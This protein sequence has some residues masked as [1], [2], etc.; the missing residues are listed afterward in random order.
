MDILEFVVLSFCNLT[1]LF[2]IVKRQGMASVEGY[3]AV[4]LGMAV[5]TDNLGLLFDYFFQP[6]TLLLGT[7]EFHFRAYPTTV[8]I[9]AMIVLM[10]GL[11]LGNPK[12]E[13]IS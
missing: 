3:C 10:A 1:L 7:Q 6:G 11:F 4:F 2:W 13:P 12:P 5:L 8:H 9:V